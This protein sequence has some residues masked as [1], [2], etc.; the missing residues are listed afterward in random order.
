MRIFRPEWFRSMAEL[1]SDQLGEYRAW[2]QHKGLMP[3]PER[4]KALLVFPAITAEMRARRAEARKR[5]EALAA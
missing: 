3:A 4:R 1:R 2:L 5:R